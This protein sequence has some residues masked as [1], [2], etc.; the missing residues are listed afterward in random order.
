MAASVNTNYGA[1]V[2]LQNL[3]KTTDQL[4]ITQERISTGY[5]VAGAKDDGA[6]FAIAQGLRNRV[7]TLGS[8]KEGITFATDAINT[9]IGAGESIGDILAQLKKKATDA[10]KAGITANDRA[11]LQKDFANLRDQIDQIADAADYNGTNL[12]NGNTKAA[13]GLVVL[14]SDVGNAGGVSGGGFFVSGDDQQGAGELF[15]G[16]VLSAT[17]KIVGDR[18]AATAGDLGLGANQIGFDD[19]DT[20]TFTLY[21]PPDADGTAAAA[22]GGN[23]TTFVVAFKTD[24]TI[25][26][27]V[28]RVNQTTGSKLSASFDSTTG[29]ISYVSRENFDVAFTDV[30][31]GTAA[32][33]GLVAFIGDTLSGTQFVSGGGYQTSS[34]L[35]DQAP[36]GTTLA[37]SIAVVN[38][39]SAANGDG[40]SFTFTKGTSAAGDDETVDVDFAGTT[41][42][43]DYLTKVSTATGGR[44]TA[45]WN[46]ETR[47][48]SYRSSEAFD[49]AA[50]GAVSNAILPA[51]NTSASRVPGSAGASGGSNAGV[52]EAYD[53]RVGKDAVSALTRTLDLTTDAAGASA[54]VDAA[55]ASLNKA[56][57]S[58][59]A[60]AKALSTQNEF[61]TKLT[62]NLIKGI[63]TLV[64]ADLAKESASL[65]A[66][67][68]KQQL[69]AQA[70]SIANQAPQILLSFFR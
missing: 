40:L 20:V 68:T 19:G 67:Q 29:K 11:T 36:H 18:N 55:I 21:G 60:Q 54:A 49:I 9:A 13:G 25:Q 7:T 31:N 69:G 43:G 45:T 51:T 33:T 3:N 52:V 30:T 48:V 59:G 44:V 65:Q 14:T 34:D 46:Q 66:L 50:N 38:G 2:A 56:L 6:V 64:D 24:D 53:F 42:L 23:D 22:G 8:V 35:A 10:Q 70:L 37:T 1:L 17:Q 4:S 16:K 5:K 12:A 28:D 62:D 41:T 15:E 26:S 27:F 47:T 63:G 58:L 61:L 57:G 39:G 32:D